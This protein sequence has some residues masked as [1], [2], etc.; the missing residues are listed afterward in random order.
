M[1]YS[2]IDDLYN[3]V[4]DFVRQYPVTDSSRKDQKI[5]DVWESVDAF[6][7][8]FNRHKIYF[9]VDICEKIVWFEKELSHACNRLVAF[10]KDKG[11]IDFPD[12]E[13]HKEWLRAMSL[14]DKEVPEV[15]RALEASF[16]EIL[17]VPRLK[18]DRS[19]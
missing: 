8:S 2:G 6:R 15:K 4:S 18:Q 11:V 17:G 5:N 1:L 16:R 9:D 13:E 7:K 19:P 12:G 14:I 3:V 10:H